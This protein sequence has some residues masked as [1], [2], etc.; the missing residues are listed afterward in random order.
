MTDPHPK[1]QSILVAE[2]ESLLR[3]VAV[4]MLEQAGFHV[5]EVE[6]GDDGAQILADGQEIA[7]LITDIQMPGGIDGCALAAITHRL[8][9]DAVIVV[10]SGNHVPKAG[11]LPVG[12]K[13]IGKPYDVRGVL[14]TL[15]E[16]LEN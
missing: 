3:M 14:R 1:I 13:F 5:I 9:P 16:M 6:N 2:D 15:N 4:D 8:H 12:A 7:G 10:V 11:E